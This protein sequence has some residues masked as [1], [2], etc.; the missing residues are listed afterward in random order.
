VPI[1]KHLFLITALSGLCRST[2]ETPPV[3]L[4][5]VSI[6]G[7]RFHQTPRQRPP[8]VFEPDYACGLVTESSLEDAA[9]ANTG[10][11]RARRYCQGYSFILD[12]RSMVLR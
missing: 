4:A 7:C 2:V 6:A 8:E 1:A 9:L 3:L 12:H 10:D 11:I 5:D